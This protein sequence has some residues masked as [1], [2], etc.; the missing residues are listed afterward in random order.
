MVRANIGED[1]TMAIKRLYRQ[2]RKV[3]FTQRFIVRGFVGFSCRS[4]QFF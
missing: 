3:L 2:K 4:C 1:D